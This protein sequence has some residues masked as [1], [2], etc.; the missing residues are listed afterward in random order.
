MEESKQ[1]CAI[2]QRY[3]GKEAQVHEPVLLDQVADPTDDDLKELADRAAEIRQKRTRGELP[4][5]IIEFAGSPKSGKSTTIEV[6][7]HFFKRMEFR[8]RAPSEGA[9]K[10]TPY[11]LR[12]DLVAFNSWTLNYAISELLDAYHNVDRPDLVILDRGPFDSLAW[13][14]LLHEAGDLQDEIFQTMRDFALVPRWAEL[15]RRIYVFTCEPEISLER[16][17]QAK[18]TR[19][20]GTAMN[21]ETLTSLR[22]QYAHLADTLDEYPVQSFDTTR[23]TSPLG[24]AFTISEDVLTLL[25]TQ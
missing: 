10:R 20:G 15:V 1:F 16:E 13:L 23:T 4:P 18:L 17:N 11:H 25:E 6:V 24:T 7:A 12:R 5:L 14:G 19:R 9:S 21:P 2:P 8:V 22:K 3:Q